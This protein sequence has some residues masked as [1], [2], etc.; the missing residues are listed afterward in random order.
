VATRS[1]SIAAVSLLVVVGV[2]CGS[3]TNISVPTTPS[4]GGPAP[5]TARTTPGTSGV[6]EVAA[7]PADFPAKEIP[8][9]TQRLV[10]TSGE[11]GGLRLRYTSADA[12]A[13]ALAYRSVLEAAGYTISDTDI[14]GPTLISE[15][16]ARKVPHHL[17]VR[18]LHATSGS[19][20]YLDVIVDK[21]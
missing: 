21:P 4:T 8:T 1:I 3:H 18:A 19:S 2:S 6:S 16:S 15:Y 5:T 9:P 20:Q 11:S 12:K 10:Y 7:L 14:D 17:D 13:D